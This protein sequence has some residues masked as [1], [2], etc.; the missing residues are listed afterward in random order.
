MGLSRHNNSFCIYIKYPL[1]TCAYLCSWKIL[2]ITV[3]ELPAGA[4]SKG[5][6][7]T[8]LQ[9]DVS[10]AGIDFGL[11][12]HRIMLETKICACAHTGCKRWVLL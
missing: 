12:Y 7:R 1:P 8:C 6:S 5:K 3:Y 10:Q 4:E 9:P 2:P 11:G